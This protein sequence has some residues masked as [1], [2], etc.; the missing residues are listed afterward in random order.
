VQHIANLLHQ[1]KK[2]VH[3]PYCW[4]KMYTG[5]VACRLLVSHGITMGQTDRQTNDRPLHYTFC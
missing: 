1:F 2:Y 3:P 4:A 5:H